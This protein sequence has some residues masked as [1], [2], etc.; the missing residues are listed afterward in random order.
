MTQKGAIKWATEIKAFQE[1]KQIQRQTRGVWFDE[2]SPRFEEDVEYRI[3]P[4]KKKISMF[5]DGEK[6]YISSKFP[7]GSEVVG[8]RYIYEDEK[9]MP[10]PTKRLPTI[11]EVEKWFLE[12]KVFDYKEIRLRIQYIDLRDAEK[13]KCIGIANTWL[14]IEKFVKDF[15][16]LDGSELYITE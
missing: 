10:E 5:S 8:V 11:Q 9:P 3:K 7:V 16:H 13:S 15:T 1:G 12:N 4:D 6:W 2:K 14:D